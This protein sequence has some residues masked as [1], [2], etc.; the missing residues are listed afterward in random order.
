MVVSKFYGHEAIRP[1]VF[2]L[3]YKWYTGSLL[4]SSVP[5]GFVVFECLCWLLFDR[6]HSWVD[7]HLWI[8]KYVFN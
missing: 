5:I 4:V 1:Q 8:I 3:L 6:I 7:Q 2:A